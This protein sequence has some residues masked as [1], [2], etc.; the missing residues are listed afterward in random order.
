MHNFLIHPFFLW[1]LLFFKVKTHWY[2]K[3]VLI[4]KKNNHESIIFIHQYKKNK[5][6]IFD[7]II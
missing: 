7:K 6:N 2:W 4:L 1:E 5:N 3:Q